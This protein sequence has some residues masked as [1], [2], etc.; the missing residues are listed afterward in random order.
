MIMTPIHTIWIYI[1]GILKGIFDPL[2][3]NKN[4]RA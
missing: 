1:N 2:V 3:Y 4:S